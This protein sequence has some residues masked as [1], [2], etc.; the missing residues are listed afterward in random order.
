MNFIKMMDQ[1]RMSYN[2]PRECIF[3]D[4]QLEGYYCTA[5]Y[6][7]AGGNPLDVKILHNEIIYYM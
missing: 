4:R 6:K 3:H 1:Y 7:K 2:K 5:Y